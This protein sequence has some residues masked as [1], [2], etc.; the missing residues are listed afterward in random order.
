NL[1]QPGRPRLL[2]LVGNALEELPIPRPNGITFYDRLAEIR[3][4]SKGAAITRAG[5]Q[6]LDL[7]TDAGHQRRILD[8]LP[9][10]CQERSER[11]IVGSVC[12]LADLPPEGVAAALALLVVADG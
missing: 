12:C 7:C 3:F 10:E 8:D 4:P 11:R 9:A 5:F 1:A 2:F 6:L